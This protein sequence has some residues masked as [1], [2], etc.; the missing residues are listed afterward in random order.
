MLACQQK[1]DSLVVTLTSNINTTTTTFTPLF[2]V[3]TQLNGLHVPFN[4][5][6]LQK[7]KK[8]KPINNIM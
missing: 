5:N 6:Q 7:P 2:R 8:I 3:Q 1:K 4:Q